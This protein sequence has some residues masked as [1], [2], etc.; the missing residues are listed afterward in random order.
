MLVTVLTLASIA[1]ML[2]DARDHRNFP[3]LPSIKDAAS[4]QS[5]RLRLS[6]IIP[7]RNEAHNIRTSVEA[8]LAQA[9]ARPLELI[10]VDDG[11]SDET[12]QILAELA[13]HH[14]GP[15]TLT[16]IA[17]RPLPA[18]WVGK[19]NACAHGA[20]QAHGE[21]LMFL[22][23]DTK[24]GKHFCEAMLMHAQA[25]DLRAASAW[26][27]QELGSWAERL[28]LPAFTHVITRVIPL[29]WMADPESPANR[30][31]GNGQC[32]L[33]QRSAYDAIGGHGAV[34]GSLLEDVHLARTLRGAGMRYAMVNASEHM[35][36]RMYHNAAEVI[37]GF[38][39]N[40]RS[41]MHFNPLRTLIGGA[42]A[43][44]TTLLP[45]FAALGLLALT[46]AFRDSF[47][48]LATLS[49]TFWW[50][51]SLRYWRASLT[52]NFKQPG[53]LAALMAFGLL[54][55]FLIAARGG[56]L[57]LLGRGVTWKGRTIAG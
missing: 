32:M 6:V 39:K 15:H 51:A 52:Q 3:R 13:A 33:I 2:L 53:D 1:M 43:T 35:R 50:G 12:A 8:V 5:G 55:Y 54:G 42:Q 10:V 56:L 22:D 16:V 30:T 19:C 29:P 28:V 27:L 26:P 24:P 31:M 38:T 20:G 49:A 17:G 37:E 41:G 14:R 4:Q 34:K 7:A 25:L 44:M 9:G 40:A 57:G 21:W 11:S 45:P 47:L 46:I 23:A 48:A 36:V 18:G